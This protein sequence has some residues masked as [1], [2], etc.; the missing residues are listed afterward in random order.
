MSVFKVDR[1]FGGPEFTAAVLDVLR[2]ADFQ[3]LVRDSQHRVYWH[4]SVVTS[5]PKNATDGDEVVFLADANNGILWHLKY[6]VASY[7]KY[8]WELVGGNSIRNSYDG[9]LTTTS[10]S[11]TTLPNGPSLTVPLPGEY[12]ITVGAR[13]YSAAANMDVFM[14]YSITGGGPNMDAVALIT[15]SGPGG[16]YAAAHAF[17]RRTTI[18]HVSVPNAT[19]TT[20]YRISGSNICHYHAPEIECIPV[21]VG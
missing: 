11:Y 9:V 10:T 18:G 19:I 21:R 15:H 12:R 16:T 13:Q 20:Q 3:G 7:S 4:P 17:S 14:S 5:L 2:S 6:R 8:R 1:R